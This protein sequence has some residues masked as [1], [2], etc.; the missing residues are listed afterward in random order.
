M[1]KF[2]LFLS[3][4]ICGISLTWCNKQENFS[5]EVSKESV[6]ML[7][8][9]DE[10]LISPIAYDESQTAEN[11]LSILSADQIDIA[12]QIISENLAKDAVK[13]DNIPEWTY[14]D[15]YDLALT[16]FRS[17]RNVS[18][19]LFK[20]DLNELSVD[21][22]L[23]IIDNHLS[24]LYENAI[25]IAPSEKIKN[26]VWGWDDE[27]QEHEIIDEPEVV[28][29]G[30]YH[31]KLRNQK[32]IYFL[33]I[34]YQI[35][36][37][38]NYIMQHY[39]L[40]K[41]EKPIYLNSFTK[42]YVWIA[43][44]EWTVLLT[45]YLENRMVA[46]WYMYETI[47]EMNKAPKVENWYI[48]YYSDWDSNPKIINLWYMRENVFPGWESFRNDKRDWA[49]IIAAGYYPYFSSRVDRITQV[50]W[51][52]SW[53]KYDIN[54]YDF[55]ND[56]KVHTFRLMLNQLPFEG[57]SSYATSIVTERDFIE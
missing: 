24:E 49:A 50:N 25:S 19:E 47:E 2:W 4:I 55:V 14:Q 31:T 48:K 57:D 51:G 9:N 22:Y 1:K 11:V 46:E 7:L 10:N 23:D 39:G 43:K 56:W 30:D 33:N 36:S 29:D 3:L 15:Y 37:W 41:S 12:L 34:D 21:E 13:E 18:L 53:D 44:M 28:Y 40:S 20:K 17:I 38:D 45:W 6:A 26:V 35:K 42:E 8:E 32:N 5:P 54:L 16:Q 27:Q 52:W